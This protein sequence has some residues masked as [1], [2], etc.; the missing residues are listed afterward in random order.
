MHQEDAK[1]R[2][3]E[4]R[5]VIRHHDYLYYV[6]DA[7]E[8]SDREYDT[9]FKELEG[10]EAQFGF[11]DA[12]SPTQRVGGKPLAALGKVDHLSAMLS[13]DSAL[14]QEEIYRFIERVVKVLGY[15]P[16]YVVEPKFDGLSVELVYRGGRFLRGSTRGDGTVG[17]DVSEN[18]KTIRSLPLT[19]RNVDG[20]PP[21]LAV[22]AE[23]IM[24]LQGFA[25]I[26][27][28]LVE[29]GKDPFA[30]PRMQRRVLC[31]NSIC[32]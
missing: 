28:R 10:L 5:D 16:A 27:R 6:K 3:L 12:D 29:E 24:P 8:I 26:N 17:E 23:V 19:L 20:L 22:R 14:E 32:E 31:G 4:L 7:P 18:L 1:K 21:F 2:V 25:E 13:L 9:L 11:S 30:N 15:E